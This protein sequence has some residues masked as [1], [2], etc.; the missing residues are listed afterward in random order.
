MSEFKEEL[1]EELLKF[2]GKLITRDLT[3]KIKAEES[4]QEIMQLIHAEMWHRVFQ[5]RKDFNFKYRRS[6]H[7]KMIKEMALECGNKNLV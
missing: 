1:V 2:A 3:P 4:A 5:K 6:I 7:S